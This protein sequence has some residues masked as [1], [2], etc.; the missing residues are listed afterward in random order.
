VILHRGRAGCSG[1]R[2]RP[3]GRHWRQSW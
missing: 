1:C 3:H 2:L